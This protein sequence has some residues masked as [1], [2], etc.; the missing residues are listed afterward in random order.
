[1]W[2]S[3]LLNINYM[4]RLLDIEQKIRV[5]SCFQKMASVPLRHS[6]IKIR[7]YDTAPPSLPHTFNRTEK[8]TV[9]TSI[10]FIGWP[11]V[12]DL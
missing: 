7:S 4:K 5:M 8:A 12:Q 1:M 3:N 9:K 11:W 10:I 6:L 2:I